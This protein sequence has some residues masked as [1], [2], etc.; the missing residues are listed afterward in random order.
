MDILNH[1]SEEDKAIAIKLVAQIEKLQKEACRLSGQSYSQSDPSAMMER[2]D[3]RRHMAR[4]ER[5]YEGLI[6]KYRN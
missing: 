6:K 1:M 3:N 2:R 5:E 4:A